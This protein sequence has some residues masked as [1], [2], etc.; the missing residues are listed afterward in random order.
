YKLSLSANLKC[1]GIYDI[2]HAS[3][4]QM[5]E[6]IDDCLFSGRLDSQV[7][8]FEKRNSE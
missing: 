3:L 8:N 4:L 1:Q 7:T 2:F 6:L 5:Y